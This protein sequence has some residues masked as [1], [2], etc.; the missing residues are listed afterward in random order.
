MQ[1][2][3]ETIQNDLSTL[4]DK[5]PQLLYAIS[6][7]A[8]FVV[9]GKFIA[10]L[11]S[12]AIKQSRLSTPYQSFFLNL[13]RWICY[14]IGFL[15]ALKILGLNAIATSI[16]AG[17][18]ITAVVLG[19]AFREIG[20]NILAGFFLAF[21]RPFDIG[22]LIQSEGLQGR[23]KGVELRHTHIRTADGCDIFVPSSQIFN[24]PLLNYT[25]D[26]LRRGGF[27]IGIDYGDDIQHAVELLR[28]GLSTINNVLKTPKPTVY[29][30]GFTPNYVE[31]QVYFW[32]DT[33]NQEES[34]GKIKTSAMEAARLK[35]MEENFTFSS[36]VIT[37][38]EMNHLKVFLESRDK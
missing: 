4:L 22:D 33:H 26:G 25:R 31:L 23:V 27:T 38:I 28:E 12:K 16:L 3:I 11:I 32:I 21:S 9:L 29:I 19:F 36:N 5:T 14:L 1:N 7:L 37:A 30:S 6:A 2:F 18:G 20:E 17:G 24:K 35:L 15:V 34:L 13:I 8:F 10:F